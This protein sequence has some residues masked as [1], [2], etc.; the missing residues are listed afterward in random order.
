MTLL[1]C[2]YCQEYK[3]LQ[4]ISVPFAIRRVTSKGIAILIRRLKMLYL[5]SPTIKLLLIK[6]VR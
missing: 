3:R 1:N 5:K 2:L 6:L 4:K